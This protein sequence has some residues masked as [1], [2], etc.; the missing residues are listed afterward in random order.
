MSSGEYVHIKR[1]NGLD[2]KK[3]FIVKVGVVG[4]QVNAEKAEYICRMLASWL[5]FEVVEKYKFK[6]F[7][8]SQRT[9]NKKIEPN[10]EHNKE[11]KFS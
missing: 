7:I 3:V 4:I 9:G 11:I 10:A 8:Q 1:L 6:T 2:G 5:G